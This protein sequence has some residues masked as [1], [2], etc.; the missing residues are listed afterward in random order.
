MTIFSYNE[1]NIWCKNSFRKKFRTSCN[2]LTN[3]VYLKG[4]TVLLS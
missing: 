3:Q 4:R 2:N 1:N